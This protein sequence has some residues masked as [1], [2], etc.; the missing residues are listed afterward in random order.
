MQTPFIEL[1]ADL[2]DL[3]YMSMPSQDVY[4]LALFSPEPEIAP[5]PR[6]RVSD[7]V[8]AIPKTYHGKV[9]SKRALTYGMEHGKLLIFDYD[10]G[11]NII[12]YELT[13]DKMKYAHEAER[14][15]LHQKL[16]ELACFGHEQFP[17][18]FGE[19]IPPSDTPWGPVT[20]YLPVCN[21]ILFVE[22]GGKW[23]LAICYP[24]WHC[25]LPLPLHSMGEQAPYDAANNIDKTL[26]YL[27]FRETTC[28][29][30]LFK[31]LKEKDYSALESFII[32]HELL[33]SAL[34][35]QA[36]KYATLE[37]QEAEKYEW[38]ETQKIPAA[39]VPVGAFLVLPE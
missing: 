5:S 6:L 17:A 11:R 14:E 9:I 12:E 18:Y 32:S 34:W 28:A 33:I 39:T 21:G 15:Y 37:N 8:Y 3:H 38:S 2:G 22:G 24:I 10:N 1:D 31:L 19:F 36:P 23:R 13:I 7:E 26:G 35:E 30:A 16:M 27:F 20:R 4:C 25:E 29:P